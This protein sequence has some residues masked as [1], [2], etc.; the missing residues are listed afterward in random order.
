MTEG[1]KILNCIECGLAFVFSDEERRRHA[2]RGYGHEPRRCPP[3]R[4]DA[5]RRRAQEAE[6]P[7]RPTPAHGHI[8]ICSSCGLEVFLVPPV[9]LA[10]PALCDACRESKES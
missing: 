4:V 7:R 3:C 5:R 9:D 1:D 10:A 8:T 2:A 6:T